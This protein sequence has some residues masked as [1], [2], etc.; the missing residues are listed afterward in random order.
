VHLGNDKKSSITLNECKLNKDRSPLLDVFRAIL[1]L[2]VIFS[3]L[4]LWCIWA[5]GA[6]SV[7]PDIVLF[8]D[9]LRFIFQPLNEL[10]PAVLCFIV[11]SGYCIHRGGIRFNNFNLK[12]YLIR[13]SFRILPIYILAIMVGITTF[14]L[15][16]NHVN[17]SLTYDM[18][19]TPKISFLGVLG[20]FTTF[21]AFI[22]GYYHKTLLGNGP[23]NTVM[24]EIILYL[25][26][27]LVM[28]FI[29]PKYRDL[30]FIFILGFVFLLGLVF[31]FYFNAK[32][33]CYTW[34]Q[35]SSV[36]GFFVYWWIG[37]FF[38][39]PSVRNHL[40]LI[41]VL[42]LIMW[43]VLTY[44]LLNPTFI[45]E[46]IEFKL[47]IAE[48]RKL[49]FAF[50]CGV[51]IT[52][53]DRG[54]VKFV[55]IPEYLGKASYSLY[56]LHAPITYSLCILGVNWWAIIIENIVIALIVYTFYEKPFMK[57]GYAKSQNIY[58][59]KLFRFLFRRG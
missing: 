32:G 54:K 58:S 50:I 7:N 23:L 19:S 51:L 6:D 36:Y 59:P 18:T 1:A 17:S 31:I 13:R 48:L 11:L 24:V 26:Y 41:I 37:A 33:S 30:H 16:M 46:A 5:Q 8:L 44:I 25:L 14:L 47:I 56:A 12:E 53:L 40:K 4:I 21:S 34:Y 55:S 9:N 29:Y 3:H 39:S 28:R 22:P 10:H 20:R 42:S 27:P 52:M 57:M 35:N 15:F 2:W 38:I 49:S 45:S 43:S